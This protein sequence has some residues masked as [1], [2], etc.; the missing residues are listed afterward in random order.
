MSLSSRK[1]FFQDLDGFFSGRIFFLNIEGKDTIAKV[2]TEIGLR[3]RRPKVALELC[4]LDDKST[5]DQWPIGDGDVV[6]FCERT[7]PPFLSSYLREI[8]IQ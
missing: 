6:Y 8:E 5:V 4:W 3:T 1:I 2:K 7:C